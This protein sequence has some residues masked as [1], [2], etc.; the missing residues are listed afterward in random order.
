MYVWIMFKIGKYIGTFAL[1]YVVYDLF[2]RD[3]FQVFVRYAM[4]WVE[5]LA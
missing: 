1:L 5:G 2:L 3:T 4:N